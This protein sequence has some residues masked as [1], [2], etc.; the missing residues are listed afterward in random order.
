MHILLIDDDGITNF[1]NRKLVS[2]FFPEATIEVAFD[3]REALVLINEGIKTKAQLPNII[4]LDINM[5]I[6]NGWEFLEQY[7]DLPEAVTNLITI[8]ILTSSGHL[9]DLAFAK[10]NP[11][12][13]S[14]ISKPLTEQKLR[15][16]IF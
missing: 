13:K 2:K 9:S 5:P 8:H 6:M 10:Q 11:L 3:G 12:V 16:I 4:L 14:V 7:K 1:I 15:G